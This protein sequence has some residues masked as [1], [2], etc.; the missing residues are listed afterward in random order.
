MALPE[1]EFPFYRFDGGINKFELEQNDN[2]CASSLNVHSY[3]RTIKGRGGITSLVKDE[4]DPRAYPFVW[5]TGAD[6]FYG[7]PS[8]NTIRSAWFDDSG[9]HAGGNWLNA[10]WLR[11][12]IDAAQ[13]FWGFNALGDKDLA[14]ADPFTV[15]DFFYFGCPAPIA[16]VFFRVAAAQNNTA[17]CRILWEYPTRDSAGV[18]TWRDLL[19]KVQYYDTIEKSPVSNPFRASAEGSTVM[20]PTPMDWEPGLLETF[21]TAP[22]GILGTR[23]LFYVRISLF[24]NAAYAN[25]LLAGSAFNPRFSYVQPR[26]PIV[27]LYSTQLKS[28]RQH[29]I[30]LKGRES[31]PLTEE[32]Y[33]SAAALPRI[34]NHTDIVDGSVKLSYI[35]ND[36]V[37][38]RPYLHTI[39]L[40]HH[41]GDTWNNEPTGDQI[42]GGDEKRAELQPWPF[43]YIPVLAPTFKEAIIMSNGYSPVMIHYPTM[44]VGNDDTGTQFNEAE[45]ATA[46]GVPVEPWLAGTTTIKRR[47][48]THD[49]SFAYAAMDRTSSA[50]MDEK[51]IKVVQEASLL[52]SIPRGKVVV[53]HKNGLFMSGIYGEPGIVRY[54]FPAPYCAYWPAP[55]YIEPSPTGSLSEVTGMAPLL[56]NLMVFGK[57]G[58]YGVSGGSNLV[59]SGAFYIGDFAPYG[60]STGVGCVAHQT[61]K[62]YKNTMLWFGGDGVYGFDGSEVRKLSRPIDP[63][64]FDELNENRFHLAVAEISHRYHQYRLWVTP[65]GY[66]QNIWCLVLNLDTLSWNLWGQGLGGIVARGTYQNPFDLTATSDNVTGIRASSVFAY[67]SPGGREEFLIG[68]HDGRLYVADE[69]DDAGDDGDPIEYSWRSRHYFFD[70]ER[71]RRFNSVTIKERNMGMDARDTA[72]IDTQFPKGDKFIQFRTHN[73][74]HQTAAEPFTV[75]K[76]AFVYS[77]S[78]SVATA[79]NADILHYYTLGTDVALENEKEY[80]SINIQPTALGMAT[81]LDW[82]I[83]SF[84]V[85]PFEIAGYTL[86]SQPKEF[87]SEANDD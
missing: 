74:R 53:K 24:N 83:T 71:V 41:M 67:K 31:R 26:A 29:T 56:G 46:T 11:D 33:Q 42:P 5:S 43:E 62:T 38:N 10:N 55:W 18:V 32:V 45:S 60:I 36:N 51:I 61:I 19:E 23:R 86:M 81:G 28:G 8:T 66:D 3:H 84:G 76:N 37:V 27:G 40:F 70:S 65:R 16:A 9:G 1:N 6:T 25:T 13:W 54:S 77:A 64:I 35:R 2:D 47:F 21:T 20:W 22:A 57:S 4:Q 59:P 79:S 87:R 80:A 72:T 52:S 34:A 73:P 39:G 7:G 85:F 68:S 78:E 17:N 48:Y 44:A 30:V 75:L 15:G 14:V 12:E 50:G 82:Q 58:L 69:A 63:I 49:N